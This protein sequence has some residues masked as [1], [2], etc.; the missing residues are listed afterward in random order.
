MDEVT[1][2]AET[3]AST[4]DEDCDGKDCVTWARLIG[5]VEV[6]AVSDV[7]VDAMGNVYVAGY[8]MGAVSFGDDVLIASGERDAF[9]VKLSASGDYIWSRQVGDIRQ[10]T[11]YSLAVSPEGEAF[12]ATLELETN[13]SSMALSLRKYDSEGA[14]LWEKPLG[15]SLCGGILPSVVS[16]MEF[17]SDGDLILAGNYC[18]SIRF[19][20]EHVITNTSD[21]GDLFVAKLRASDG[22]VGDEGRGWLM[23]AGGNGSQMVAAI[24]VDSA[25]NIIVAGHFRDELNLDGRVYPSAGSTDIFVI[26]LTSRGLVSW[27]RVLGNSGADMIEAVALDRLGGPL[28]AVSFRG[29]AD[30]GGGEVVADELATALVK[31]STSNAY[32]WI[33]LFGGSVSARGLSFDPGGDILIVGSFSGSAELGGEPLRAESM[34][35]LVLLRTS[36]EGEPIW[37][38]AFGEAGEDGARVT[39]IALR[40]SGDLL[41]VGYTNGKIDLGAGVMTPQGDGDVFVASFS[42]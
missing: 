38:R 26:K 32:E 18:G 6:E 27:S 14:L 22:S 2:A 24:S 23:T 41:A 8:F 17:H 20:E 30:F 34:R 36:R 29:E 12:L 42:P 35:D 7:A 1:P 37:A 19:G 31:Y 13:V 4:E 10:E 15:G 11:A 28:L 39:S 25:G 40:G 21:W 16:D 9:L 33:K 3:C 5:G